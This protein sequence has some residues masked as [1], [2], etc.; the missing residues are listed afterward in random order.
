MLAAGISGC[1]FEKAAV[2]KNHSEKTITL[3]EAYMGEGRYT[4]ALREFLKAYRENPDDPFLNNDLGLAY[5][6]KGDAEKAVFHFKRAIELKPG[7]SPAKNNLGSAY[8]ALKQWDKAIECFNSAK[9]D[10]LY[11]TPY[12]PLSNLG[13]VYYMKKD[14]GRAEKY[15]NEALDLQPDFPKALDGL[16]QVY[17]AMGRYKDAIRVLKRAAAKAPKVAP[18]YMNLAKAYAGDHQYYNAIN[19]YKKVAAMA[20]GTALG[21]EAEAAIER[22]KWMR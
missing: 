22:L 14:Y 10:L 9:N 15:Y 21:E 6:A 5:L 1:G 3:G 12:F 4:N 19:A 16:G 8:I 7:Y 2:R 18:I 17:T 20:A 13:Y 11:A